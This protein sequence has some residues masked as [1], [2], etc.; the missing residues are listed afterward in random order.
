MAKLRIEYLSSTQVMSCMGCKHVCG[1]VATSHCPECHE[2]FDAVLVTF[3]DGTEIDL[4]V[5]DRRAA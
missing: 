2:V 5:R 4:P 1:A 3:Q